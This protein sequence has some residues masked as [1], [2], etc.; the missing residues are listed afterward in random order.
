[1]QTTSPSGGFVKRDTKTGR[2]H[3]I[4]ESEARDKVGHA[5]R[6]VVQILEDTKPKTLERLRKQYAANPRPA[7][8]SPPDTQTKPKDNDLPDLTNVPSSNSGQSSESPSLRVARSADDDR[9]AGNVSPRFM[10]ELHWRNQSQADANLLSSQRGPFG[11]V[12]VTSSLSKSDAVSRSQLLSSGSIGQSQFFQRNGLPMNS[13]QIV[14]RRLLAQRPSA[15]VPTSYDH[16]LGLRGA[17]L[18]HSMKLEGF[19]APEEVLLKAIQQQQEAKRM[20]ELGYARRLALSEDQRLLSLLPGMAAAAS[21]L[22]TGPLYTSLQQLRKPTGTES[23][24]K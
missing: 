5:L 12:S 20:N 1:V 13:T 21:T 8:A 23:G 6:K 24:E 9:S 10:Q 7:C 22:A 19:K 3:K 16:L 4:K 2:W 14:A 17:N 15:S 18:N 11:N